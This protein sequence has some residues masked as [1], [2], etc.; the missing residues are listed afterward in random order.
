MKKTNDQIA[1]MNDLFRTTMISVPTRKVVLTEGVADSADRE[2][3]ITAVRD[4]TD[5]NPDNDPYGEHDFGNFVINGVKYFFKID[6]YDLS[7][8]YGADPHS[9]STAL[10]LTIM[11]ADEY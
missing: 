2:E 5:F 8:E 3:I 4:Y 7:W 1:K 11:R 6:Y 10:L 9:E